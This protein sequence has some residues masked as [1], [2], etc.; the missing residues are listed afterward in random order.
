MYKRQ[1]WYCLV[2]KKDGGLRP[3]LDLRNLNKFLR[4]RKFKMVTLEAIIHLLRQGD[5]FVVVD[6][7]D[8]YFHIT[9]HKNHRKYLRLFFNNTVYQFVALPFGL[10]T[11]PRTFTKCMAPVAAYL[12]LRGIQVYPYIDDWLIVSGSKHQALQDTLYVLHTLQALGLTIN[13]EKSKL[14]PSQVVDYIGAT[15]NSLQARMFMP[16]ERI[17]KILKA[18]RRFKPNTR[19]T[20]RLA[21]HLLGLMASTTST[22]SHARLKMRC[23]LY[24]SPSPRD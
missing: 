21:Q 6:L 5:W 17:H 19:V 20:A 4:V 2:P 18:I 15:I 23:L 8:A 7:K 24:T 12:R 1:S 14:H 9:I 11:V 13:Y 22:L 3:I 16:P 10:S